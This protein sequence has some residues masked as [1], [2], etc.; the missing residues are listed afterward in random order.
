MA[1]GRTDD[2][3]FVLR[4]GVDEGF[5][6]APVI[7]VQPVVAG[8]EEPVAR[9]A[10]FACFGAGVL[11]VELR[12]RDDGLLDQGAELGEVG[13]GDVDAEGLG[14]HLDARGQG[15]EGVGD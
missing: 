15:G 2:G 8:V 12:G 11:V 10:E 4:K 5:L 13:V 7:I 3:L 14:C 1:G 6:R 9:D